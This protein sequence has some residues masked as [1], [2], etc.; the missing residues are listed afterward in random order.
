[1]SIPNWLKT[2]LKSLFPPL[3][4]NNPQVP[5]EQPPQILPI[6]TDSDKIYETAKSFL[7]LD[8]SPGDEAPSA[9]ACAETVNYIVQKATGRP[10]GGETSTAAMW[11]S[12]KSDSSRWGAIFASEALPGD[13]IISPTGSV[14]GARLAHGHVGIVAKFGILSNN[15]ETGTLEENYD[16]PS[17][18]AYYTNFGGLQTLFYRCIE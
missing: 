7:G 10:V 9:L 12:L 6:M 17:W 2:L 15:S 5:M 8:A 13:I 4:Y 3:T 1:M 11:N 14:S 18:T 16:I